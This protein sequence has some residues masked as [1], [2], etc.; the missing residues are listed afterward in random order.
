MIQA[1]DIS[2]KVFSARLE[3]RMHRITK[4]R[5]ISEIKKS[6]S[7]WK[8][9]AGLHPLLYERSNEQ[10]ETRIHTVCLAVARLFWNERKDLKS[11]EMV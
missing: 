6:E 2:D 11:M 10:S 1:G 8:L 9:L 3:E 5:F 4:V 7:P